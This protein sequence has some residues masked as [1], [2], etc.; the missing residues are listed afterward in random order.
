M[1]QQTQV[2]TVIPFF[3]RFLIRF[4]TIYDLAASDQQ[5]ILKLWEGLG[6]YSRARN[7]HRAAQIIVNNFKGVI[8]NNPKDLLAL[9]GI[10]D[11][12]A[13]AILSIAFNQAFAVVD[14]NVKRVLARLFK[15]DAP[16]NLA[17]SHSGFKKKAEDMLYVPDPAKYNQAIMELGA[18]VCTPSSPKCEICPIQSECQAYLSNTVEMYPRRIKSKATPLYN[19]AVGVVV[20]NKKILIT[21]RKSEGLL[22]GLWEFP[23]GRIKKRESTEKACVREILEKTGLNVEI[24]QYLTQVKHAFTHFRITVD[25]YICNYANGMVELNGPVD[26]KWISINQIDDYPLHK[27]IHKFLP[28]LRKAIKS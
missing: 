20:K 22:G 25:V 1:L 13:S 2:K 21:R 10:G 19:I 14:G 15:M 6:Y 8:P 4:P 3:N 24:C 5:S 12:I 23:G 17:S 27:T 9:P 28:Q 16:L 7:L 18:L 11:Y 26:Y